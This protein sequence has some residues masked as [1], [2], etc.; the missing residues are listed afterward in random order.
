MTT[1]HLSRVSTVQCVAILLTTTLVFAP[2]AFKGRT[3]KSVRNN[4]SFNQNIF[5]NPINLISNT[6]SLLISIVS[7]Q[8]HV[9]VCTVHVVFLF[10]SSGFQ[11]HPSLLPC[12][13]ICLCNASIYLFYNRMCS[14]F[15]SDRDECENVTCQFGACED[16]IND[17]RCNCLA[18]YEGRFCQTGQPLAIFLK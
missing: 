16:L 8:D 2:T 15:F 7:L 5:S 13:V 12:F 1:V 4:L 3:A 6:T 9:H 10:L 18:G 17:F 14:T 11:V